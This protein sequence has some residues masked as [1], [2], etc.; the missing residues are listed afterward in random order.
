MEPAIL[1]RA[2]DLDA[3]AITSLVGDAYAHYEPLIGRTPIPMLAD[4]ALAVREHDVWV[5]ER[6]GRLVGVLTKLDLLKA[7]GFERRSDVHSYPQVL[8]Q[9]V[10]AVMTREPITV[11]SHTPLTRVIRMMADTRFKSFPV[12][13]GEE[14]AG[15]ISRE[16]VVRALKCAAASEAGNAFRAARRG[17]AASSRR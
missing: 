6:V 14:V 10:S 17:G 3:A 2:G 7:F 4:Y 1:R 9:Q 16:D 8:R 11:R 12:M 13:M 15:I 5:L